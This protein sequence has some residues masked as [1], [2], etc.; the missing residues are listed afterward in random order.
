MNRKGRGILHTLCSCIKLIICNFDKID[1]FD[2]PNMII[3]LYKIIKQS[4]RIRQV[5]GEACARNERIKNHL[6]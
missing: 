6:R 2:L 4:L 5:K 1:Y 3:I